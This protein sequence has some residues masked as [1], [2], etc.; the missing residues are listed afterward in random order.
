MGWTA[1]GSELESRQDQEFLLL[2]IG[3]TGS[4]AHQ[5]SYQI[6]TYGYFPES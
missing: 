1:E 5:A 6:G 2:H 3:L 4:G